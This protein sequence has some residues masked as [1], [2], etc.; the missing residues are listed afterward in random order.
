MALVNLTLPA[1]TPV[2]LSEAKEQCR[3][4]STD[5]NH[6][7]KLL[8]HISEATQ[9][10]E[11]FTGAKLASQSVRLDLDGFPSGK[12]DLGVYPVNS[13]TSI[14]YDDGDNTETAMVLGT[15]YW[16]S[17]G[18]MYP[19]LIGIDGWPAA[20][21]GKP[22]SVRITMSVGYYDGSPVTSAPPEDL[23]HAVLIRVKEYFDNAAESVTG[24]TVAPTVSTV[25][26]LTDMHRR[27]PI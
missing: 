9:S 7:A 3:I 4:I 1:N 17:L 21:S 18:G 14:V 2:T 23:K 11:T 27:Y 19:Y 15:D 26:A 20:K 13:I 12:I 5:T 22:A 25:K 24:Q 10:I 8:R 6:D 16:E